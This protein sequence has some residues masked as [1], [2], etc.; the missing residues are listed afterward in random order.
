MSNGDR[1]LAS[2]LLAVVGAA[3]M[4]LLAFLCSVPAEFQFTRL[5]CGS[6]AALA[7]V[8]AFLHGW[9]ATFY[10]PRRRTG[11]TP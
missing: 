1:I 4:Y 3:A 8:V 6:M 5:E 11:D 9:D 10:P 2:L 7:A